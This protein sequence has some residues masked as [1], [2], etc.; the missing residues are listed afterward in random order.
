MLD[1]SC[2]NFK[3]YFWAETN[4]WIV[5]GGMLGYIL[6]SLVQFVVK[7]YIFGGNFCWRNF[8]K[9]RKERILNL[10]IFGPIVN[11]CT[12]STCFTSQETDRPQ[13]RESKIKRHKIILSFDVSKL[14]SDSNKANNLNVDDVGNDNENADMNITEL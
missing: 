14:V 5:S 13:N 12:L 8:Q 4:A 3:K 6:Q 7:E 1:L 9:I 2:G 11:V 10:L